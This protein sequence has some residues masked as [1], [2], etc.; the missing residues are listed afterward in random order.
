MQA[1]K[2]GTGVTLVLLQTLPTLAIAALVTTL[3]DLFRTFAD[4]PHSELLVPM[5]LTVPALCVALFSGVLGWLS[6]RYGRR[7]VLLPSLLAFA[8]FGI[9]PLLVDGLLPIIAT[10]FVV[11]IAEAG[12]LTVGNALMGDY[13]E[14]EERRTWLS[15]QTIA[16][17]IAAWV[18]VA[19]GGAL[20][21]ISWRYPFLVYLV[22]LLVFFG[23]VRYFPEPV[24]VRSVEGKTTS[25]PFP[26]RT[27]VSVGSLTLLISVIF[28]V[29]NVQH[30][31]IF[32][33]LGARDPAMRAIVI[34][35]AGT[36]SLIAGII[37]GY[38]RLS[39]PWYFAV[40]FLVFGLGYT[41]L[42]VVPD[43]YWGVLADGLGQ[44][45]SGFAIPVMIA[46]T[47]SRFPE[48]HR[49]RGTGIWAACFFLGEFLSPPAV[50]A[51]GALGLNFL[52]SVGVIGL[53]CLL[54]AVIAAFFARRASLSAR[55]A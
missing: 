4:H 12:I 18:Y 22:G 55:T 2:T 40:I 10:R 15:R 21:S 20:G 36:F 51:V 13:Y 8:L 52:Q 6:D 48:E 1:V 32:D 50:S 25:T 45:G 54:L 44:L 9:A 29:Q 30:G 34:N 23:A 46:W 27:A 3:P 37:Y 47:L 33:D 38:W 24:R 11:G 5:I 19:A 49:G 35:L 31:R 39:T 14:G 28:F 42:A 41:A 26:W 7:V 53:F 43:F 16:G 17:P